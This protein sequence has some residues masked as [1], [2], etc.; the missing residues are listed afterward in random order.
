MLTRW[1]TW[2]A[3]PIRLQLNDVHPRLPNYGADQIC[4]RPAVSK[5]VDDNREIRSIA[6]LGEKIPTGMASV[7]ARPERLSSSYPASL[8]AENGS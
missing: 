7:R 3:G 5:G 8:P 6:P 2:Q 4:R 1:S